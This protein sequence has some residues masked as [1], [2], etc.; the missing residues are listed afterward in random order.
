MLVLL[1]ACA[2]PDDEAA[3]REWMRTLIVDENL[4]WT[5]RDPDLLA[6]KYATMAADPYDFY[7]GTVGFWWA[8][9]ARPVSR[10][11][12]TTFL[13]TPA[14]SQVLVLGDGHI[15]NWATCLPGL[16]P[17][18]NELD[19]AAALTLEPIDLDAATFGPWLLDVRRAL[20]GIAY[21]VDLIGCD[22]A[23]VDAT[24]AAFAGAYATEI[25]AQEAGE[26]PFDAATEDATDGYW[27]E[28]LRDGRRDDGMEGEALADRTEVVD[29]VRRFALDEALDS[30]GDGVLAVTD[31]ERALVDAVLRRWTRAP[32]GF[33]ALGAARR[34][35][36][37]V[38]SQPALRFYVLWD[39]GDDGLDDDRLLQVREVIDPPTAPGTPLSPVGLWDSNAARIEGVAW[40]LWSRPD[41][42]ALMSGVDLDGQTFKITTVTGWSDT[43]DHTDFVGP[44]RTGEADEDDLARFAARLGRLHAAAHARGLTADGSSALP[45]I[46]ADLDGDVEGFVEELVRDARPDVAR[47]VAD[48]A[49]FADALRFYG[50]LLGVEQIEEDL[51]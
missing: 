15:E 24:A 32:A 9:Q 2:A 51:R 42:D 18:P 3:R 16:E 21:V 26:A 38:S 43:F 22:D 48:A 31:A 47:L 39:R 50:P 40:A 30:G 19:P 6:A 10:R 11:S 27:V 44:W 33:R 29:G 36:Q 25:V 41:A 28:D 37:G 45:V 23:C 7:R 13:T 14:A 8:D 35:G 34:F 17:D 5:G 4:V 12:R 20:V 1:I 46:A 49:L